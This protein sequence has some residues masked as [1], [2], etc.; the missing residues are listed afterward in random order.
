LQ[1]QLV[2]CLNKFE[3]NALEV[4]VVFVVFYNPQDPQGH[5]SFQAVS[6]IFF[7]CF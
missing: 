2:G 1:S 7:F 6:R 4:P 3:L 5:S